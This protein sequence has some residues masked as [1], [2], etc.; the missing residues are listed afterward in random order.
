MATPIVGFYERRFVALFAGADE[1]SNHLA[2]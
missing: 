1:L 2:R